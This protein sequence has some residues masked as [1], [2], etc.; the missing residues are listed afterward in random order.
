MEAPPPLEQQEEDS[1]RCGGITEKTSLDSEGGGEGHAEGGVDR[2]RDHNV[3]GT[4][5]GGETRVI[6]EKIPEPKDLPR[7]GRYQG[8]AVTVHHN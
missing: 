1:T 8:P 6:L 2:R 4:N 3:G 5:G 7:W